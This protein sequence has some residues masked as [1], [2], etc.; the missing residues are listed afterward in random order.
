MRLPNE[1][2]SKVFSYLP[3]R[4]IK[5][6]ALVSRTWKSLTNHSKFWTKAVLNISLDNIE[7]TL[8]SDR[9]GVIGQVR[10]VGDLTVQQLQHVLVRLEDIKKKS[11]NPAQL[12]LR[13]ENKKTKMFDVISKAEVLSVLQTIIEATHLELKHLK[14]YGEDLSSVNPEILAQA[15]V[16]VDRANLNGTN[17]TD[18][19]VT[20]LFTKIVNTQNI[21]LKFLALVFYNISLVPADLFAQVV[22]KLEDPNYVML[23]CA[24]EEQ[25]LAVC[26]K[27]VETDRQD[28]KIKTIDLSYYREK[29][30]LPEDLLFAISLKTKVMGYS[31]PQPGDSDDSDLE[32]FG[33]YV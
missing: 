22:I 28:L 33:E 14:L 31:P 20:K 1:I 8:Q 16:R 7:E 27:I 12:P 29:Y 4:D 23:S 11:S 15:V 26:N 19:Q 5:T 10:L 3:T 25:V 6:V 32:D 17:L 24:T 18:E 2:M 21:N 13:V 30:N 9:L